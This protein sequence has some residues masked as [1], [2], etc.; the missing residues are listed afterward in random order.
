MIIITIA[1][2]IIHTGA[3]TVFTFAV[4]IITTDLSGQIPEV[5]GT[6]PPKAACC[7]TS[8]YSYV[9]RYQRC[10][11][12]DSARL[13][14]VQHQPIHICADTSDVWYLTPLG[15]ILYNTNLF[16]SVQIPAVCGT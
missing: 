10:V 8:T 14:T 9:C 12:L 5:C 6:R 13:H 15:C 11:V 3:D 2:F 4:N 1:S 7:T 16:I